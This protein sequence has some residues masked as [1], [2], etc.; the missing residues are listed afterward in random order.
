MPSRVQD[1]TNYSLRNREN[2]R[3][4]FYR[5]SH[6]FSSFIPSSVR[7]WTSLSPEIK[8]QPTISSFKNHLIGQSPSKHVPIPSSPR[9]TNIIFT[10]LRCKASSLNYD[11]FRVGL[12]INKHCTC[13][14]PQEDVSHYLFECS[15]Y[16]EARQKL[17]HD[18]VDFRTMTTDQLLYGNLD[19][20][21]ES[22]NYMFKCIFKYI[23]D[24]QRF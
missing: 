20:T 16:E 2:Y 1:E 4:P 13:G 8:S 14:H 12:S 6:A 15:L 3:N 22:N 19:S 17:E 18:V 7:E 21:A 10:R 24:S 9:K 23:N 11:L 5:T